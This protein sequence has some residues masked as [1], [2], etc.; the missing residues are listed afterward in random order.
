MRTVTLRKR[1]IPQ[2]IIV[3]VVKWPPQIIIVIVVKWPGFVAVDFKNL[4]PASQHTRLKDAKPK[5]C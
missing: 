2:I 1:R 5:C 3:I 4:L